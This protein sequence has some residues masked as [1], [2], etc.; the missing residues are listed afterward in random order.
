MAD[1]ALLGGE[2][3][4]MPGFYGDDEYDLA[5]FA[6]GILDASKKLPSDDMR[7]GDVLIAL[8]SSG[9]HSNGFSLIR[10]VF[11]EDRLRSDPSLLNE[12]LKPTAIY[13]KPMTRLLDT[14]DGIRAAAHITGGGFYE[15]LPRALAPGLSLKIDRAALRTPDIFG[16]I[17]DEGAVSDR[18]MFNTFNMGMGMGV[19]AAKDSADQALSTLKAN[20]VDAYAL[21]ETILG[22]GEIIL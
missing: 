3:A 9:V 10:R 6:V 7:P 12:L 18:D 15:N 19:I 8:P 13:V 22:D 1:C 4:E 14:V 20:G 17:K 16:R 21:G 11:T 2:T 5:G